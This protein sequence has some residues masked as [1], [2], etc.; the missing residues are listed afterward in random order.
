ME[1]PSQAA[2][3]QAVND[4]AHDTNLSRRTLCWF[5][6][7]LTKQLGPNQAAAITIQQLQDA[8]ARGY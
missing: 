8:L 1:Q 5:L 6:S 7:E 2:L 3:L 4:A